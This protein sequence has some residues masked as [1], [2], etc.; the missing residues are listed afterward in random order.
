MDAARVFAPGPLR[1][2]IKR[3]FDH[4]AMRRACDEVARG[5][6]PGG[7]ASSITPPIEQDLRDVAKALVELQQLRRQADYD[8]DY[9][10]NRADVL[11]KILLAEQAFAKWASVRKSPNAVVFMA[12]LLFHGRWRQ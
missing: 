7:L 10:P 5:R 8:L 6:L 12:G 2:Q 4:A 9:L 11:Q 1:S 3:V